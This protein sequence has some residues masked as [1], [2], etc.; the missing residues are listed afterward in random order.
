MRIAG[1]VD[2]RSTARIVEKL[3]GVVDGVVEVQSAIAWKLDDSAFESPAETEGEPG[4]ASLTAREPRQ[5]MHR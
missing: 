1:Q 5:P 2:R 3:I 4:A